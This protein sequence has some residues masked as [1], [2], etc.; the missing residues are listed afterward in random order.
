LSRAA[1]VAIGPTTADA[2]AALGVAVSAVAEQPT[3]SALV[4]AAVRAIRG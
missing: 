1:V 4:A 3:S 2:L